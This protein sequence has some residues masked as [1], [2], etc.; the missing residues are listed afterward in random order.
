MKTGWALALGVICGL[1]GAG[2][3]LLVSQPPGGTAITLLPP[4]SPV[5]LVVYVSGAVARPDIYTMPV[6]SRVRDAIQAA[7]GLSSQADPQNLN[8]AAFLEDGM[9][10]QVAQIIKT[11]IA[12]GAMTG[13][14]NS[15]ATGL[16]QGVAG[17]LVNINTASQQELDTLPEI[18]PALAQRIIAYRMANG[19][20][21]KVE[22][23]Q[24]VSGI[25]PVTFEKIK[26]MITVVN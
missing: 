9:K 8:L 7:G 1:L 11:P 19:P 2:I 13:T 21:T 15:S 14:S 23:I 18:G 17:S 22:D 24:K 5:P 25:G 3:I 26:D 12:P 10:I 20:F 6:G 16:S 4:P